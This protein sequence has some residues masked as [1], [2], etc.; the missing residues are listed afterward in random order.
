MGSSRRS[1]RSVESVT[2]KG[3]HNQP[4]E[5]IKESADEEQQQKGKKI[6]FKGKKKERGAFA[7]SGRSQMG[8]GNEDITN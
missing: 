4:M 6:S 7:S 3:I 1:K 5:V 8:F 2:S